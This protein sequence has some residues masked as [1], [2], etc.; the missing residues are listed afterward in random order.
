MKYKNI[1]SFAHNF[2][3]SF[4]SW[5]NNVGGCLVIEDLK[6]IA[7]GLSSGQRLVINW[8]PESSRTD[9]VFSPAVIKSIGYY[10]NWLP[11]HASHHD[12]DLACIRA[13]RTEIYQKP[14]HQLAVE[15]V[16]IDD[17]GKEYRISLVEF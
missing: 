1:R 11:E 13:L 6:T 16:A 17:R 14:N 4:I 12:V 10:R 9:L 5:E 2:T 3:H 15:S 8:I 7:R